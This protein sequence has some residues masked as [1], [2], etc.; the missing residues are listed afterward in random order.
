MAVT[1]TETVNEMVTQALKKAGVTGIGE[2]ATADDAANAMDELN[3]MLKGWQNKGYNLWTK[4]GA[5]LTLTTNANHTLSPVRP[6]RILSAR[7]KETATSNEIPMIEMTRDEY[8]ELPDKTTTGTPTQFY[9]DRQRESAVFYVWPVLSSVTA[10][11]VEY[12]YD[13]EL[14]DITALT[15]TLDMPGEWWDAVMY[16]LAARLLETYNLNKP[17]I[18]Q[19]AEMLLFEACAFDR[20]ASITFGRE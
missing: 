4:T 12:T 13:R 20:E 2:N 15:E 8:D 7:F 18:A 19:R 14:E 17:I 6:L 3:Y 11:T 5:S 10:Q 9:Y 1:G 16:S